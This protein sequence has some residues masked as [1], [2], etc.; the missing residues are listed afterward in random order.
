MDT[1]KIPDEDFDLSDDDFSDDGEPDDE[2]D[3]EESMSNCGQVQGGGCMY[4]GSE[5][6]DWEC[7]FSGQMFKYLNRKRDEKG[8]FCK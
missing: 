6:C 2:D 7:P 3:F 4:I 1:E 5:Y 8:R